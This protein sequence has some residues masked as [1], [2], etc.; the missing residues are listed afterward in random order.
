MDALNEDKTHSV[1][2]TFFTTDCARKTWHCHSHWH[3]TWTCLRDYSHESKVVNT[4]K[5]NYRWKIYLTLIDFYVITKDKFRFYFRPVWTTLNPYR[6]YYP[7]LPV[8]VWCFQLVSSIITTIN[9][10]VSTAHNNE[11]R[12][13]LSHFMLRLL[14]FLRS[15]F[16]CPIAYSFNVFL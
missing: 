7:K 9:E 10:Y 12:I 2:T 5:V 1:Q 3:S 16:C 8:N 15:F 13:H 14:A 11:N 4:M 6:H